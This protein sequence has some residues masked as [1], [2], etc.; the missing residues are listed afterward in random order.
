MLDSFG[1]TRLSST[2][3]GP[4]PLRIWPFVVIVVLVF[5][6]FFGRL[7]QLQVLEY[8]DAMSQ[9]VANY[10][11]TVRLEA[12]RGVFVD[13][14]GRTI[15][16]SRPAYGVDLIPHEMRSSWRVYSVLGAVLGRDPEELATR[17][18]K[19]TGRRRFQPV[20]LSRDL[21]LEERARLAAHRYALPGVELYQKPIRDYVYGRMAAQLLGTIGEIGPRELARPEFEDYRSGETV[22]KTGLEAM[23]EAHLRGRAGGV[24]LVVDVAGR[25]I[26]EIDRIEP[27][28]G[29]RV[30][31]T[32]DLDLQRAAEEAFVAADPEAPDPMGALIALDPHDGDVL[33]MVSKPAYDANAFAGAVD[34]ETWRALNQDEWRPLRNRAIA[35]VYPPGSTYKAIVAAAGLAEGIVDETTVVPCPGHYRLGRRVYRCWKR[36]GHGPVDLEAA[37]MS[38]CDV[39]FYELGRKLGVEALARH[40]RR[41][42]LGS[43]TGIRL[44]GEVG[45]LVPTP[46]WKER[47]RGEPWI[48]GETISLSIGQGANLAT[49]IQLAVAYSV[50]ANG[51]HLIRPRLVLRRETWDGELVEESAPEI[52]ERDVLAPAILE[53]VKRGLTRVVMD[54]AGTGGR[55][56]VPGISVA[57][58]SGTTQVVSLDRVEG[59]EP[60]EIPIRYRDHAL[61]VAF[62]PT[63]SPEIVVAAV[64]EHA[65]GGG[66]AVAAPMVQKVLAR[67]FEK[68]EGGVPTRLAGPGSVPAGASR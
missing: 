10:V 45:A 6:T 14:E 44:G 25:E 7:F 2:G 65:N 62:A 41:F 17:V 22:G 23:H 38:S 28:P 37:L 3:D 52:R 42:G 36:G 56:R 13:R 43:P 68:R 4:G 48:E 39:Y 33:A 59:L 12:Q 47:T 67:Y 61:F 60:E 51:G 40:A 24:N 58:K 20:S 49:P 11:R 29:G 64:V 50:I 5:S 8:E 46:E 55:A 19:P 15:A 35:G 31:L 27:V 57:G 32:L 16:A 26:E 1:E 21:S 30:V 54:P 53:V 66:G 63:E 34:R 18:G 9:K